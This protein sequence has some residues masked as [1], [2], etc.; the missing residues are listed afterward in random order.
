MHMTEEGETASVIVRDFIKAI[1][2]V[3]S[4]FSGNEEVAWVGDTVTRLIEVCS[5]ESFLSYATRLRD[6][7]IVICPICERFTKCFQGTGAIQRVAWVK[8]C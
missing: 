2:C 3:Y 1:D 5:R 8:V 6:W 7:P 4:S